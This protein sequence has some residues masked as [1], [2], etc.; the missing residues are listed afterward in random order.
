MV[1]EKG[2]TP[3]PDKV[4][5]INDKSVSNNIK[6]P[7]SFFK[8]A[9]YYWNHIT[10]FSTLA[11]SLFNL[12]EKNAKFI[13]GDEQQNAFDRTQQLLISKLLL[14]SPDSNLPYIIQERLAIEFIDPITSSPSIGNEYI[15]VI[16]DLL[17][18]Y[19]T[20]KA[21]HDNLALPVSQILIDNSTHLIAKLFNAIMSLCGVC[22]I[23]TTPYN[24]QSND[25]CELFNVS[26]CNNK[27]IDWHD[28]LLKLIFVYKTS[29]HV[30]IK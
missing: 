28:Q 20:I 10:N 19:V 5:V 3:C 21:T 17:S 9:E 4:I 11:Q 25:V 1:N 27:R 12:T 2:I 16:T 24:S 23:F 15:L 18:N 13:W 22:H 8:V 29:R 14:Q 26:I 30:S 7:P 6:A